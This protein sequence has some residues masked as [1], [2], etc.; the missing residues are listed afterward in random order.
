[1]DAVIACSWY[2]MHSSE[3]VF[4]VGIIQH[5]ED[6]EKLWHILGFET[7]HTSIT[8]HQQSGQ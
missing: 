1:M 7:L 2:L 8:T 4:Q 6:V 3:I 5:V